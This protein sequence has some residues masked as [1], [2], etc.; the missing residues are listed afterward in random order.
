MAKKADSK[1][2]NKFAVTVANTVVRFV[3]DAAIYIVI[4]MLAISF[5][6][7]AY[8]FGYRLFGNESSTSIVGVIEYNCVI[9]DDYDIREVAAE[10]EDN[11]II[12]DRYS[13]IARC[14][15]ENIRLTAGSYH[16]SSDMDYDTILS[17]IGAVS[18][19]N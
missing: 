1:Q 6:G 4:A 14:R 7:Y 5:C 9:S 15:L 8:H 17:S 16:L 3:M 19:K 2:K 10:L 13:F 11:N 12:K 18:V